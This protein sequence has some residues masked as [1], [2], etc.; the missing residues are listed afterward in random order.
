MAEVYAGFLGARRRPDRPPARLPRG[1]RLAREHARGPRLRQRR[2]G[3][4]RPERLGER[5]EVRQRHPRHDRGE[6]AAA[7]RARQHEDV[8]PLPE[9]LGDGVQ[10]AVQDVEALRVQRRHQ[11]PVHHLLAGRDEGRRARSAHQYHHAID[12]VPTVLDALGVEAPG[13]IK[14]HVQSHFDGVSMRYSFDDADAP[15]TQVDAV[16]LDARLAGDLAR[17]LEG[18]HQPSDD[19]RL[20]QLQRRRVGAVPHRRRPLRAARPRRGAARRSCASSSEPLVRR[21]R[22]Q[23]RLPARRPLGA[24]DHAHAAAGALAAARTAT[25]TSRT[26]PRCPSRRRSTSATA[27]TRSARWSTSPPRAPKACSSRTARCSAATR[28]TSRTTACTTSTTSSACSSRRSSRP[29]TFPPASN[30]ILS[31]SFDKA[32][33]DPPGVATGTLSLY[34]GDKKVG[35]AQIKTQP[36][37]VHDRRR[38]PLHRPRQRRRRHRRLPG[39]ASRAASPAARSG[40]SPSTS[41]ASRTSTSSARPPRCCCAN[42][43]IA[44]GASVTDRPVWGALISFPLPVLS[45]L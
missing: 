28:C 16:L 40:A 23:R 26:R 22:R 15:S 9:R 11:R 8:Q 37:E 36:G 1:V 25:S 45:A 33:E 3:R 17:R 4:G 35:E 5:D 39:H 29:R 27:R 18:R 7:R 41:A 42:S 43:R 14:G 6:P 10:H 32:G 13:T 20:E 21:G 44:V 34:H 38:R 24:R 31:A 30:L 2:L 19:R 12:L